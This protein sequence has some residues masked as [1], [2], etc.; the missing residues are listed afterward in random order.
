M[1]TLTPKQAATIARG[2]YELRSQTV[3]ETTKLDI[4]LG[5]EDNFTVH[6]DSRFTGKSG[7]MLFKKQTGFGYVAAGKGPTYSGHVLCATRGTEMTSA[8]DWL[9][10]F[11]VGL[12]T[13]P[14]GHLVHA[15]FHEVWKSYST[16]LAEFLRGKDPSHVHCVGH[17]LGGALA[18]L[19]A[20]FFTARQIPVTV[21]T[22]GAP[23]VGLQWLA[24]D[25]TSRV[26]EL[27]GTI[28]R[29]SHVADPVPMIPVFPFVHLPLDASAIALGAQ[30]GGA[31][32]TSAHG[33]LKSYIPAVGDAGWRGLPTEASIG[34][35][36]DAK[37]WLEASGSSSITLYS[38]EVLR[39]IGRAL[40]WLLK[41]AGKLLA[42]GINASLT[43]ALTL[44]DLIAYL[45][46]RGAELS[47]E[48]AG[49]GVA[50]IR[51]ILRFLGRVVSITLDLTMGFLRWVF[52]LLFSV[53]SGMA[54]NALS[55][56]G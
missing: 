42:I 7:A 10:N 51:A 53:V 2:V 18:M 20:D 16:S 45:I 23:R 8:A 14:S 29:V 54:R 27:G 26:S 39:M 37:T 22:F 24:R 1:N 52:G 15:G 50:L 31:V 25:L 13:G 48:I 12:Q 5:C 32:R 11:N 21:Y 3:A 6:E 56:I 46:S 40:A 36:H 33:M 41:K 43:T 4:S 19:N 38:A 17:S 34:A 47:K 44:P 30:S 49:Y 35:Q 55:V 28:H 9:S